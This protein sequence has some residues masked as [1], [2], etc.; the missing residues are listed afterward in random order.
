MVDRTNLT[1]KSRNGLLSQL[2]REYTKHFVYFDIPRCYVNHNIFERFLATGKTIPSSVIDDMETW[3]QFP[4]TE[5]Y[6]T[7]SIIDEDCII[8]GGFPWDKE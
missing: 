4:L 6:D 2:P 5:E 8:D 1:K 3:L 7:L